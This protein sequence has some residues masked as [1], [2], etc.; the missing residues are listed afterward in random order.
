MGRSS[1]TIEYAAKPIEG[2]DET[3]DE[4]MAWARAKP[5]IW[6]VKE[7]PRGE[8]A[9]EDY[10]RTYNIAHQRRYWNPI[11]IAGRTT[12]EGHWLYVRYPED[13]D[14]GR[15]KPRVPTPREPEPEPEPAVEQPRSS[16]RPRFRRG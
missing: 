9:D 1:M 10:R 7:W 16:A 2:R 14:K 3:M 11:E 15:A 4:L 5:G 8:T 13:P 12:R 6:A